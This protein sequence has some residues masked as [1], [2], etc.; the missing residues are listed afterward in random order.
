MTEGYGNIAGKSMILEES[1]SVK[2]EKI[3]SFGIPFKHVS[4]YATSS[5]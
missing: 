2:R 5:A 3:N 1:I 4:L